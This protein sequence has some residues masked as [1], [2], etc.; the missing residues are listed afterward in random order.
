MNSV[1]LTGRI[2]KDPEPKFTNGGGKFCTFTI[3]VDDGKDSEGNRKAIFVDC[4]AYKA[5]A[6]YLGKYV[7][8]G[9]I[10]AVTGSLNIREVEDSSGKRSKFT[11]VRAYNVENLSPRPP[12]EATPETTKET[13]PESEPFTDDSYSGELPF[14][15]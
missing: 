8:K 12:V 2:T 5:S 6:E 4:I 9:N 14:Q 15:I 3:A 10:L 1:T 7:K 11:N 13:T